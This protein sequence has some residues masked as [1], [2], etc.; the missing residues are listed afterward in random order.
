VGRLRT[1]GARNSVGLRVPSIDTQM[2]DQ[3]TDE[4][5]LAII[6]GFVLRAR[7]VVAHSLTDDELLD[8]LAGGGWQL[9]RES[10]Q[11]SVQRHLPGEEALE[12]L[13]ARVR[14]FILNEDPV[15]Y[16]YVLNAL[17]SYLTRRGR[18]EDV[19]WCRNVLKKDW[20][21][22]DPR[23]GA[24][25]Y[26]VSV[27]QENSSEQ[28]VELTDAALTLTWFYG[29]LVHADEAQVAAGAVFGI[30]DRYAAAAVRTAQLAI[31][32]RD[33]LNFILQLSEDGTLPL[34]EK[35]TTV[36]VKVESQSLQMSELL[37][38]PTGTTFPVGG[39]PGDGWRSLINLPGGT[40]DGQL[41]ITIPWG[42]GSE[43]Q[44]P[45][46]E[47]D[48]DVSGLDGPPEVAD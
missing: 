23:T 10:G 44:P 25:T 4:E 33:T 24:S 27:T 42:N 41:R 1:L 36:A 12:S 39:E 11:I 37:V 2:V 32:T 18:H 21:S 48:E 34:S 13:A 43:W 28:A 31:L 9:T 35:S 15:Q 5:L 40:P 38:G 45:V 19:R 14:P 3:R 46:R 22:V 17:T 8:E 6:E 30:E 47:T 7:R 20:Q 26:A 16:G 29:D